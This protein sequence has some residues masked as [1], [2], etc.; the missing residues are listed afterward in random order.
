[1]R[2]C[3]FAAVLFTGANPR[4]R[5]RGCRGMRAVVPV[6]GDPDRLLE[7]PSA[8]A[9]IVDLDKRVSSHLDLPG[10]NSHWLMLE[11]AVELLR[12]LFPFLKDSHR[13]QVYSKSNKCSKYVVMGRLVLLKVSRRTHMDMCMSMCMCMASATSKCNKCKF[14]ML[15]ASRCTQVSTPSTIAF[16]VQ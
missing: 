1:M 12:I 5:M 6:E 10:D 16:D 13:T 3:T 8:F 7:A 4:S 9:F 11:R 15:N 14:I 2:C